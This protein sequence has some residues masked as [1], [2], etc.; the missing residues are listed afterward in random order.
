MCTS[1]LLLHVRAVIHMSN[2][3]RE[4]SW[5]IGDDQQMRLQLVF[6]A[7]MALVALIVATTLA[8][9]KPRGLT[10]YGWRRPRQES[11]GDR[12]GVNSFRPDTNR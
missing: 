5:A 12:R 4:T 8:L 1:L 9:Y 11:G 6:D 2:A 10:A 3:A 7:G